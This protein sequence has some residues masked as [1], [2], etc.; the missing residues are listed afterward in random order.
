[1][2]TYPGEHLEAVNAGQPKVQQDQIRK[3]MRMAVGILT[4]PLQVG[5]CLF[6]IRHNVERN[7]IRRGSGRNLKQFHIVRVVFD[8][9][10][11]FR[12]VSISFRHA[13]QCHVLPVR[14]L[15]PQQLQSHRRDFHSNRPK[16]GPVLKTERNGTCDDGVAE[17][18]DLER[19]YESYH[20]RAV[21]PG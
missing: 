8:Y 9:E 10:D 19:L 7:R 18:I 4:F 6:A 3:R 20:L 2:R 14:Q 1:V 12:S 21:A 17:A 15:P 16:N 5:Q 11:L 13:I